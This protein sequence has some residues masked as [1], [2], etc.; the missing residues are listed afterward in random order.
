M[1]FGNDAIRSLFI[2]KKL[3][4]AFDQTLTLGRQSWYSSKK[5]L[6]DY[7]RHYDVSQAEM[8]GIVF[9]DDYSEPVLY[10]LGAK[11]VDSIDFSDYE[12][13][14]VVHDLNK[15]IPVTLKDR[16]S[17][18]IDSGTLEHIFN[19]PAA[20]K[21]CMEMLKVNGFFITVTNGNNFLGHGFYQ[22][23]PELLYRV[24]SPENGFKVEHMFLVIPSDGKKETWYSVNDPDKVKSRINVRNSKQVFVIMIAKKTAE[25]DIFRQTPQ[26]SDY[27]VIWDSAKSAETNT[28][29]TGFFVKKYRKYV[30]DPVKKIIWFFRKPT[31]KNWN[32][33]EIDPVHIKKF[34]F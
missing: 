32:L 9:E 27:Q 1:G 22:F 10:A 18:V 6:I 4:A 7:A 11:Q 26:Q 30:P 25:A 24:F 14:T 5:K 23:S 17:M 19:F 31:K 28:N 3:G 8:E 21:N 2:A 13:A 15:P 33:G 16:Y 20:I 34:K 12:K 29:T